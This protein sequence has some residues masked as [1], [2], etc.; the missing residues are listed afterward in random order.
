MSDTGN[1]T[2]SSFTENTIFYDSGNK[3]TAQRVSRAL[4]AGRAS[5]PG[6][7]RSANAPTE[8]P[9]DRREPLIGAVWL[10]GAVCVGRRW[11]NHRTIDHTSTTPC[12]IWSTRHVVPPRHEEPRPPVHPPPSRPPAVVTARGSR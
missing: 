8:C 6:P 12:N 7:P 1:L 3:S 11:P 4:G 9:P 5:R 2:T 10:I